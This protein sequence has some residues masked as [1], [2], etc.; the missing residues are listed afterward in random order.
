MIPYPG[1]IYE[2]PDGT[3][4][5]ILK[6]KV[7]KTMLVESVEFLA[8]NVVCEANTEGWEL[9]RKQLRKVPPAPPVPQLPKFNFVPNL[10]PDLK[11]MQ[12]LEKEFAMGNG[13][14]EIGYIYREDVTVLVARGGMA[15]FLRELGLRIHKEL[16]QQKKPDASQN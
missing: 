13:W 3:Q 7:S 1:E 10:V 8:G 6:V 2:H 16:L 14:V 12:A 9:L 15:S 11:L 5:Q 4:I